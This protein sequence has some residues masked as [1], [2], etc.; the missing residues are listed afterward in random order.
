MKQR[1]MALLIVLLIVATM[2]AV[3]VNTQEYWQRALSRAE[4]QLFRQQAK[5]TLLGAEEWVRLQLLDTLPIERIHLGQPWARTEQHFQLD[6]I[7]VHYQLRDNQACF[8]LNA[9]RPPRI[10][11]PSA[12]GE[13]VVSQAPL[14]QR[15]FTQLLMNQA[16]NDTQAKA[17][18]AA[19][20]VATPLQDSSQLRALPG[21]NR[22]LWLRLRPLIC[23]H[24]HNRLRININT[25]QGSV[26]IELL[27]ALMQGHFSHR[28]AENR[29]ATRPAT[30]WPSVEALAGEHL[31]NTATKAFA[32]LQSLVTLSSD[33]ME[34]LLWT[35]QQQR[36][37]QLRSRLTRTEQGFRVTERRYGGYE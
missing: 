9:V 33:D 28:H 11:P 3:A 12:D 17:L 27:T 21:V 7:T 20:A 31:N 25:L 16:M 10:S 30:G 35:E 29:L 26:G 36:S 37:Y 19:L 15:V 22:E 32:E 2:A 1:G 5:W 23:V 18:T 24:P 8:N 4:G 14:P 13:S 6:D 34:L